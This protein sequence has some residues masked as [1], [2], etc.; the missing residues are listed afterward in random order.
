MQPNVTAISYFLGKFANCI[1]NM[2]SNLLA[3]KWFSLSL[4]CSLPIM[5]TENSSLR[6]MNFILLAVQREHCAAKKFF[7]AKD[8]NFN[9]L[10]L[11][12][13]TKKN[14]RD[15]ILNIPQKLPVWWKKE[16]KIIHC[17]FVFHCGLEGKRKKSVEVLH[18]SAYFLFCHA[19]A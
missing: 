13:K 12:T 17:S 7:C 8:E 14:E 1:F 16:R 11:A 15:E 10:S 2:L 6:T 18:N 5:F 3:H 4:F 19:A 9:F